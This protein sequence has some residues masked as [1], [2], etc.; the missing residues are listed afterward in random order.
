MLKRNKW[1][2]D[3]QTHTTVFM[4]HFGASQG[5]GSCAGSE[6]YDADAPYD[7]PYGATCPATCHATRIILCRNSIINHPACSGGSWTR[8]GE[9]PA[10]LRETQLKRIKTLVV[11]GCAVSTYPGA[12]DLLH[13]GP[14]VDSRAASAAK[15]SLVGIVSTYS[16][17]TRRM[18]S[19]A[20][21]WCQSM[22][23]HGFGFCQSLC[24]S[25]C[26]NVVITHKN[27]VRFCG[28]SAGSRLTAACLE[29]LGLQLLPK[30]L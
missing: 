7:D 4:A 18:P 2:S 19:R 16:L 3:F 29:L 14:A 9:Y 6:M 28:N 12:A 17:Y 25:T 26:H 13:N 1:I 27:C 10:C 20:V 11:H 15:G 5:P 24:Q 8:H 23:G 21:W 30:M 22:G